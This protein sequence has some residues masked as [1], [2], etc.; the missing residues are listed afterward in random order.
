[1][2]LSMEIYP[3]HSP[4]MQISHFFSAATLK[5]LVFFHRCGIYQLVTLPQGINDIFN[6]PLPMEF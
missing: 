2:P 3:Q 4:T 6:S 1:M 5:F